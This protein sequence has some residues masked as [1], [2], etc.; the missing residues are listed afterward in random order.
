[1][2]FISSFPTY[3]SLPP[4]QKKNFFLVIFFFGI[5]ADRKG[6]DTVKFWK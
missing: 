5:W 2:F 3:D 1:M 4:L 6:R